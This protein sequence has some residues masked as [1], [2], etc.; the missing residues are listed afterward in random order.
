MRGRDRKYAQDG[1]VANLDDEA[2]ARSADAKCPLQSDVLCLKSKRGIR[3]RE[4]VARC[5]DACRTSRM[6][7]FD[8]SKRP[9]T[10][11][12]YDNTNYR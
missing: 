9:A 5:N 1:I 6:L 11:S 4:H 8:F 12:L 2:S 3:R 7:S 10:G